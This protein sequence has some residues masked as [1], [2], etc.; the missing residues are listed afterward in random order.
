MNQVVTLVAT[1]LDGTL[2]N[3]E[4]KVTEKTKEAIRRLKEHGILFGVVSGRPVESGMILCKGWGLED[5]ISFLIGMN[6]GVLYDTRRKEKETYSVLPGHLIWKVIEHYREMPDLHFEV[7]VGNKRYVEYST[8]E[9]LANAELYG[10]EEIIVDL[11]EFLSDKNVNKLIIRSKPEDQPK[12]V[13][14]AK[15]ID[16]PGVK[17]MT[18]SDVLFEFVDPDINKGFG[19]QKVCDHFG[20]NLDN[21]VAFGDEANDMEML[22]IAGTGVAMQNAI[23]SVKAIADVVSDYTNDE[24]ALAHY[25]NEVILPAQPDRI[26]MDQ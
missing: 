4:K 13:E 21:I 22:M 24:D 1:D 25:I 16:L 11:K 10:E 12:V 18:T 9:T 3:S 6:G 26:G 23:P 19:V 8:P 17:G 2:L 7:M 14:I 20:L 15:T 5:S